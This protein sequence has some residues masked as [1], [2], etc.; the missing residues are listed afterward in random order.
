[1]NW[2]VYDGKCA[3]KNWAI[4]SCEC[5]IK[6]GKKSRWYD[7]SRYC[8]ARKIKEVEWYTNSKIIGME[9]YNEIYKRYWVH[10]SRFY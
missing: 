2:S 6:I 10:D 1:M 9:L 5:L 8:N 4:S 7:D 3:R